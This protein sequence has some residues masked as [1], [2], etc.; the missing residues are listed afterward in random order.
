MTLNIYY[1]N[2]FLTP[3]CMPLELLKDVWVILNLAT[4]LQ[5]FWCILLVSRRKTSIIPCEN[6]K[7]TFDFNSRLFEKL[8]I[9]KGNSKTCSNEPD[10]PANLKKY[11][12]KLIPSEIIMLKPKLVSKNN[13]FFTFI[14][15]SWNQIFVLAKCSSLESLLFLIF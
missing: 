4:V 8:K 7:T 2:V 1:I 5:L 6:Y 3:F 11:K 9:E 15:C 14:S 12:L 13:I 10:F